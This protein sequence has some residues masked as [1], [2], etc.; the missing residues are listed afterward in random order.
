MWVGEAY[1]ASE[2]EPRKA[3]VGARGRLTG[4]VTSQSA[5]AALDSAPIRQQRASCSGETPGE[6]S[7]EVLWVHLFLRQSRCL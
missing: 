1:S 7:F 5:G 2:N 4:A 3:G 6:P